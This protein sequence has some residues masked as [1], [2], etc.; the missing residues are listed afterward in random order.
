MKKAGVDYCKCC[1]SESLFDTRDFD[2]E[3][4]R[5]ITVCNDCGTIQQDYKKTKKEV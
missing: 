1:K 3:D 5:D 4:E 2:S